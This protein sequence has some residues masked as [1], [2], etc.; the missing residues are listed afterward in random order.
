MSKCYLCPRNC[1]VDRSSGE[2]GYCKALDDMVIARYS[3]HKWE[4]PCLSGDVGSGTIFFSYCNMK[5]CF[6]QNYDISTL[7]KGKV[8]SIY[9]F[10]DIC[11]EL[12]DKG[13]SNINLVTGTMYVPLIVKGLRLAKD[14]GLKISVIYNTSSYENV[15]T[16]KMLDGLVDVYLPDLKYYDDSLAIK[17]SSCMDYFKYASKAIEEMYRQVS[18]CVFDDDGMIKKGV[19]VRHLM[20]PGNKN[21]SKKIIKYLY[22][23][24]GDDIFI[25]I[26]NQYTPLRYFDYDELNNK[27]SD[28]DYDEVINYAYDMGIRNAFIQEGG[29]QDESFIPDF[30]EFNGV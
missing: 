9:E 2:I 17:Y 14:R 4:E 11:L 23:R 8:V 3:L 21:D 20:L 25:S 26:M 30:D 28:E 13:A 16:I 15:D 7:H 12:Q 22:D 18:S 24:Y 6:C 29:T 5:C 27:V 10:S 1:G 19:I